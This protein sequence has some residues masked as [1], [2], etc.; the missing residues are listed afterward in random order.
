M[1]QS[2][3]LKF[4]SKPMLTT[5]HGK[6][7]KGSNLV[8]QTLRIS[9]AFLKLHRYLG[10][11]NMITTHDLKEKQG[12]LG[13]STTINS[14]DN[15]WMDHQWAHG[16]TQDI[17]KLCQAHTTLLKC[18]FHFKPLQC[19]FLLNNMSWQCWSH[20]SSR[21]Q[22]AGAEQFL[23]HIPPSSNFSPNTEGDCQLAFA[24]GFAPLLLHEEIISIH[25]WLYQQCKN[26][27]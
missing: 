5:Y 12:V 7:V 23:Y 20:I 17:D 11:E 4:I 15:R 9:P 6:G 25:I 24:I 22:S 14:E 2:R 13:L 19:W 26:A 3:R 27:R 21:Q 10:R 1:F 16:C 18:V 8:T